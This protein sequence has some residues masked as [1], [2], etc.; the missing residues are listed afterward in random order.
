M[1]H[2]SPRDH[3]LQVTLHWLVVALVVAAFV[4]G[5][6]MSGLANVFQ[7][8]NSAGIAHGSWNFHSGCDHHPLCGADETSQA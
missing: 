6:T 5:K 4:L 8:L 7:E 2:L 3:P 1:S